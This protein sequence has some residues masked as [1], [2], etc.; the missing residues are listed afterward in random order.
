MP[1]FTENSLRELEQRVAEGQV[2]TDWRQTILEMA[3]EIRHL[4][5][6]NFRLRQHA[7]DV[8]YCRS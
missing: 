5:R 8:E 3:K 6:E 2:I 7:A 1:A 4:N